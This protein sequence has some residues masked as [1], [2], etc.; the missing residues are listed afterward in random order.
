M[1]E[2][3]IVST[4]V[5]RHD[6]LLMNGIPAGYTVLVEGSP[7]S[8]IELLSKQFAAAG[9]GSE[10]VVYFS[11][12]ETSE[13]LI[14]V[15][16]KHRWPTDIRII[17]IFTQYFE[18]VL[19]REM[20]A[21]RFKQEGLSVAEL[22]RMGAYGTPADQINFLNDTVYEI[23]KIRAPFRVVIDSLDF[24]LQHYNA[25]QV[26][27]AIMTIK[28]YIQY[29]KGVALFTLSSNVFESKI[30]AFLE[31]T[32][33]VIFELEVARLASEFENRLIVKKVR[34][35]PEKTA[36]MVY[37]ITD[38]GITPEMITRIS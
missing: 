37:A 16:E 21:S 24:Y 30:Q 3:E 17:N 13:E 29:N 32:C 34:N 22:T 38:H 9:V 15:F 28:A 27:G 5:P 20:Q 12:D 35:H 33:D 8:G 19:A 4:G 36:I 23:S 25:E 31:A 6:T 10:N 1:V 18:K 2:G 7:G 11:T 14:Q 26:L